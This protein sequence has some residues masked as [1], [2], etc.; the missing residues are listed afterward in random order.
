[1]IAHEGSTS[2]I[3]MDRISV[4]LLHVLSQQ[5]RI[6]ARKLADNVGLSESAVRERVGSLERQ[7]VVMGYE[8]RVDWALAGLPLL[9]LIEGYCPAGIVGDI[10]RQLRQIPNVVQAMVTTGA[11]NV[12]AVARARDTQDVRDLSCLLA[13]TSLVDVAVSITLEPLVARRQPRLA[14]EALQT[15]HARSP[16][17]STPMGQH[18]AL[19][20]S[21]K[22]GLLHA[23]A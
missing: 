13:A 16:A 19:H 1:M 10:A 11:P 22:E 18:G 3:R 20:P 23:D 15:A 6:S 7:G 21:F 8:A 4:H 2:P 17:P 14:S 9:V 5:G 12:L